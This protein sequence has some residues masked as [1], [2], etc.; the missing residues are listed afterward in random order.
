MESD[1]RLVLLIVFCMVF[2][3]LVIP[4]ADGARTGYIMNLLLSALHD[5]QINNPSSG[6]VLTY[7]GS[8][9]INEDS[10]SG[11]GVTSLTSSNSAIILN[12]SSGNILITPKYELL[13]RNTGSG[14]TSI[15]CSNLADRDYLFVTVETSIGGAGGT[16]M[17]LAVRFN[18]DSSAI[19][20]Y[21]RSLNGGADT[22]LTAQ[23][24]CAIPLGSTTIE[25]ADRLIYDMS[26]YNKNS[27]QQKTLFGMSSV[28]NT[29]GGAPDRTEFA[30][31][32]RNTSAVISSI[33]VLRTGGSATFGEITITVWGY[34]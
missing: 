1:R 31:N 18:G 26:I 6:Q 20:G 2:T 34:D 21:R 27:A 25:P 14:V 13:C 33:D 28:D 23:T 5:V 8:F 9:W 4:S 10:S 30:C 24:S 22:T 3:V 15:S 11:G 7:N 19:Y 17:N 16:S 32:W 12:S 29:G